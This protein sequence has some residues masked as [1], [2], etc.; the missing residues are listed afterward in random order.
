M[1]PHLVLA[2]AGLAFAA[3]ADVP[4][5]PV[6]PERPYVHEKHGDR[7]SDPY[8]W[9]RDRDDPQVLAYLKAENAYVDAVMK[10]TEKLQAR[11]FA[12][13]KG[14]IVPDDATV[15]TRRGNFEYYVRYT[16]GKEH[17]IHC[18]RGVQAGSKEEVIL[19]ANL[20][21]RGTS[22][23]QLQRVAPSPDHRLL[24]Y[25][26]DTVGRRLYT[27]R[28]K[29]LMTGQLLPDVIADVTGNLA[30]ANDNRTLFYTGLHR[31][32]LRWD[33]VLRHTLGTPATD[34]ALVYEDR[35]ETFNVAVYRSPAGRHVFIQS[36]STTSSEVRFLAA[37]T[38]SAPWTVVQPREP[39]HEYDVYD[40]G[41]RLFIRTN[42]QAKNFRLMEA[43]L[44]KLGKEHWT[45]VVPHRPDTLIEDVLVLRTH[46]ALQTRRAGLSQLE[47]LARS[48]R[49]ASQALTFA[50]PVYVVSLGDNHDFDATTFRYQYQSPT[51]PESTFD[52]DLQTRGQSLRKRKRV[53]GGFQPGNYVAERFS[54]VAA[55][56]ARV[57][58]SLVRR[59][60]TPKSPKT[61]L[62]VYG[63]GAYGY[64]MEPYFNANV[65]SL[66][67]RGFVYAIAHV[68]GGSE[69]GRAWYEDGRQDKKLNTF[70]DFIASTEALHA[71]GYSSPTHT[72]AM[73]GSAG[74]LLMG[75][76]INLR[77]ELYRGVVAQVPF[78]D[79]VTT[80]LDATIPLT[81]SEYDEWGNPNDKKFYDIIKRYSP[82]DNVEAKA[83][84]SLLVTA[85]LHDSQVQYWE[86]AKWVA[87][88]RKLKTDRN[89]LLFKVDL[90]AGHGGK[91]GRFEKLRL[92]A[93]EYAFLLELEGRGR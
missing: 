27:I 48:K 60:T 85:G 78:V 71:Q 6:A 67:D 11:L 42:L 13:L 50:D 62:L 54:A 70:T 19:D 49:E 86:P 23:F 64:S 21:A 83:Y 77:P 39:L 32:T 28:I 53:L 55:D 2:L 5:P 57:P 80:M 30:W 16:A 59:K 61:P 10:P 37:D 1:K 20:L 63:Y 9:L 88:L 35:D 15:P 69:L 33:R 90:E 36:G 84:P 12:E 47:T 22:F 43:A 79:A 72:Y 73:G 74:G 8:F 31:E 45:D 58:V 81:T 65:L 40:G 82:Y 93:L 68:R 7:R 51:T 44:D 14:R 29:D 76:V 25:A 52:V 75:A 18:R 89:R 17:P 92:W 26:V 56:G 34:D 4:A 38:P 3:H 41:D 24:A 87:R 66:L 46:L 91:S